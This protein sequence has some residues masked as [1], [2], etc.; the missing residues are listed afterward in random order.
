MQ[1][2]ATFYSLLFP[3]QN[4]AGLSLLSRVLQSQSATWR[5]A[6]LR[7]ASPGPRLTFGMK[8]RVSA[9]PGCSPADCPRVLGSLGSCGPRP[10]CSCCRRWLLQA[11]R[12]KSSPAGA[13]HSVRAE[14]GDAP[15]WV[16]GHRIC[17]LHPTHAAP[18]CEGWSSVNYFTHRRHCRIERQKRRDRRTLSAGS[19]CSLRS[20]VT[21]TVWTAPSDCVGFPPSPSS[22]S[23]LFISLNLRADCLLR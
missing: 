1:G 17:Q 8:R 19:P 23:V 13:A 3:L 7:A 5:K 12:M 11:G 20:P 4:A 10:T 16:A 9:A 22:L 18:L 2:W 21:Q 15:L 14:G 6:R